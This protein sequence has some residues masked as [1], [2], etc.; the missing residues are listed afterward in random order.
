MLAVSGTRA[1][2]FLAAEW[3]QSSSVLWH[4]FWISVDVQLLV[5]ELFWSPAR[6]PVMTFRKTWHQQNHWPHFVASSRHTCSG[7]L[8]L[9]TCWTYWMSPVD[10]AVVPLY[11][12]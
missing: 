3:T 11:A 2:V 7:N 4:S 9:A 6:R 1:A 8:L 10:L 12:T 5:A